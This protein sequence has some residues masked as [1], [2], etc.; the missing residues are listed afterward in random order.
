M[1]EMEDANVAGDLRSLNHGQTSKYDQFWEECEKF[2]NE[3][4]AVDDRRHGEVVHLARVISVR[5]LVE[6]VKSQ[7]SDDIPI[8]SVEWVRLQFWPKTPCSKA[9]L[10]HTGRLK[11]KLM[12]QQCQWRH[13]HIDSHYA[14]AYF[15]YMREYA[16]MMRE[17]CLFVC[18]DD[19][20]KVKIG[21]PDFPVAS[22]ERGRRV[23]VR[24][25]QSFQA[26]DHDFTKFGIVPS[27]ALVIDIPEEISG[28]WYAGDVFVILKD[29]VF[30]PSSPLRHACELY[31]I[32]K[33]NLVM[34]KP[35]LFV[36]SDGGSDHRLTYQFRSV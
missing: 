19:K 32:I 27:V 8:P 9:S 14:A 4:T 1:I 24:A 34:E 7:C 26:G 13:E 21:E 2:L 35:V 16:I 11:V 30:E 29:S 3:E 15:R 36:Y 10:H 6:Q 12:I 31:H 18:L 22:A 33:S 20:H 23:P 25:N 5:D 28:S 17:Y